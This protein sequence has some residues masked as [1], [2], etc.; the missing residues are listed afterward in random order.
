MSEETHLPWRGTERPA[1]RSDLQEKLERQ[2]IA[3]LHYLDDVGPT[4]S[5]GLTIELTT[6]ARLIIWAGRVRDPKFTA[7][8]Y[9]R[10][11]PRPLIILPRMERAWSG[12]RSRD[13]LA[14]PADALQKY[15]E[16]S[17]I[18][19]VLHSKRPMRG[20]GE[21]MAI[22]MVGGGRFAIG[23]TPAL[24]QTDEGEVLLAD[25]VYQWSE[26]NRTYI[27]GV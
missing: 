17:M 15:V 4:G 23:A 16:G 5:R 21:Q 22:E 13:P 3:R 19:G 10:W 6:G 11:L 25:L 14:E 1:P 7:R 2:Q 24:S 12:G 20:G 8:L 18:H 27:H 26:R 9:F